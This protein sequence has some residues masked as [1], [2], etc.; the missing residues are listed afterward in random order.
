[1]SKQYDDS[2]HWSSGGKRE[3]DL[4]QAC[5]R[6][7]AFE[8]AEQEQQMW[9][10]RR[11]Q[12]RAPQERQM[13]NAFRATEG[14]MPEGT[15][16]EK[17]SSVHKRN[18]DAAPRRVNRQLQANTNS[19]DDAS[20]ISVEPRESLRLPQ[21]WLERHLEQTA[22]DLT[23]PALARLKERRD[24][25]RLRSPMALPA[26]RVS[27]YPKSF[28][29]WEQQFEM[30]AD[31]LLATIETDLGDG[32]SARETPWKTREGQAKV[33][34][35]GARWQVVI[36]PQEAQ[37]SGQPIA[38]L[39]GIKRLNIPTNQLR[40]QPKAVSFHDVW[41]EVPCSVQSLLDSYRDAT[42]EHHE[43]SREARSLTDRLSELHKQRRKSLA[44][45]AHQLRRGRTDAVVQRRD[46]IH[47]SIRRQYSALRIMMKLLELRVEREVHVF[48][49]TVVAGEAFTEPS[50]T[51]SAT[52][53]EE[54]PSDRPSMLCLKIT[55]RVPRDV[56]EEDALVE[57]NSESS[58]RPKRA[59]V[60]SI[61]HADDGLRLEIEL[62]ADAFEFGTRVEVRT[63]SRFGMWAHARAIG[64]LLNEQVEG[65]WPDLAK[66]LVSPEEL[67]LPP[68]LPCEQFFN[69]AL[70]DRQR[71]AV[72]SALST[73]HAFC[74]QGPPGT[75]KTTV[76]C[77]LVEQLIVKGERILLVAPTHVAVDEVLRRIGARGGVRALRL[78]WNEAKVDEDVRKYTPTNILKPF[79]DR[80]GNLDDSRRQR[81]RE[82]QQSLAHAG[83]LLDSLQGSQQA[84]ERAQERWRQA[85]SAQHEADAALATEGPKLKAGLD[86]LRSTIADAQRELAARQETAVSAESHLADQ[87]SAANWLGTVAGCVGLGS[88]G[89]AKR[90]L[91]R[92]RKAVRSQSE[93]HQS[94]ANERSQTEERLKTLQEAAVSARNAAESLGA[95]LD[96]A[97]QTQQT[98]EEECHSH[99]AIAHQPLT[100]PA[101]V[102]LAAE[103]QSRR[104]RLETYHDLS[105]RFDA[106]VAE[107]KENNGDLDGLRRDLLAVT[108]LFCC[109]T[110]G[111][112]GSPE[113][114]DLAFDT[115]ILD[116]ASRVTDAEF[117]IGA[118][119]ARRWIMVGDEHQLPPYVEQNDEHFLHALSAL[120][121][122]ESSLPTAADGKSA[123]S[124]AEDSPGMP[125]L[126]EDAVHELGDLWEE[127][128]ELHRFRRESVLSFAQRILTS[129]DWR[130]A[131]RT[132]YAEGIKHLRRDVGEPSR[133][134]LRAMRDNLVRSLFER[135]VARCSSEMKERLVEQRRMIEPI[136]AIVSQPVYGGDY[137]TPPPEV[138]AAMSPPVVPLTTETFKRP[139]TFLDTTLYNRQARDEIPQGSRSFVNGFE[140]RWVRIACETLD[141][142]LTQW[143]AGE[144]T[145]SILTFYKAQARLIR[146]Q[147]F[148]GG[149][150]FRRLRFSVIDAIDKIQGQ[151]SDIVIISFCRTAGQHVPASF[152]QWLQD[153]RRLNVA[154]TRA[155]RAL[156]FVGQR[157]L[158]GKL[159]AN[160]PAMRFYQHLNRMLDTRQDVM[161][162]TNQFGGNRR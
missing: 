68:V 33:Q 6:Y 76:I 134:L 27:Y 60:R 160:E 40:F 15:L 136:A 42:K 61:A 4:N 31:A 79:L 116:E 127:D 62:S 117:L 48:E 44:D 49:A 100:P 19:F 98:A 149:R 162:V 139:I 150:R 104:T 137:Q 78:A 91:A 81:W 130:D 3:E 38:V 74:I 102:K 53:V 25:L 155:H 46:Q 13:W 146:D 110:T 129:G 64:D 23:Q 17:K 52:D 22:P 145:I 63:V 115:L 144:V 14:P 18:A 121:R 65:R 92:V 158:L 122:A 69:P 151:E 71:R 147:L 75:G 85:A 34:L 99:P 43:T 59:L 107:T 126:L 108:N 142:E 5:Q 125:M 94:L 83:S 143:G 109:T 28:Q 97:K 12:D 67:D 131:Y 1:M 135:V 87:K 133:G 66:L 70:N 54:P 90:H 123:V 118:N 39:E 95:E 29:R 58:A 32:V 101:I 113:L 21:D 148:S 47:R 93:A 157:R 30:S 50:V 106:L 86:E 103:L 57:L 89:S 56:L 20:A 11:A 111:I 128:E 37:R 159:C 36:R 138:L 45:A 156:I 114:K 153:V 84:L 96:Q 9:A 26:I 124:L 119:R 105:L 161:Y 132:A 154:C 88:V 82:E 41:D 140:A 8:Q 55:T 10:Q 24:S 80:A 141:R 72:A 73:P 152:G 2:E 35:F 77:E 16:G 120:Y 7:E 112:A 51:A